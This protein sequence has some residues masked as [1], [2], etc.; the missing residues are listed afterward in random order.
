MPEVTPGS[1][2]K[3]LV[4]VAWLTARVGRQI[5]A[6]RAEPS[7]D[8]LRAFWQST[9]V[10]QQHWTEQ[11]D[12]WSPATDP[13]LL[14][15]EEITAQFLTTELM[16]RVWATVLAGLDR[17]TGK[18]DLTRIARNVVNGLRQL[19]H[20]VLSQLL[21]ASAAWEGRAAE[22]DRLRRRCDRWTDLLVGHVAGIEGT[23]D[24][25]LN[26]ER[27]RDF[28]EEY[29]EEA[30]VSRSAMNRLVSTGLRLAF[31]GQLPEVHLNHPAFD[32]MTQSVLGSFPQTAFQCDGMLPPAIEQNG[33]E[34][35]DPHER[36]V[37]ETP[38]DPTSNDVLLPGIS[39]AKLRRRF[40]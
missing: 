21:T 14:Q 16:S 27:A 23:F 24:F 18:N 40:R 17:Q 8:A 39:F 4:E 12:D 26:P 19:R 31:V 25:A 1:T 34:G 6:G 32:R 22:I 37:S 36:P 7:P 20:R 33:F 13:E 10:L 38:L 5:I 29:A 35:I 11:L 28:A 15:L 9:R 3:S 2:I 30:S